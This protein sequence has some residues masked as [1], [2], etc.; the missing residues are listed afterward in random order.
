MAAGVLQGVLSALALAHAHGVIH[1]DIKPQN[2]LLDGQGVARLADFGIARTD[3]SEM[4][5]T[6]AVMGTLARKTHGRLILSGFQTAE[7]HDVVAS[8]A[9][10]VVERREQEDDWVCVTLKRT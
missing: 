2:I 8:F 1:R 6:G 10:F 7:E 9:G 3:L 4:T 5:R